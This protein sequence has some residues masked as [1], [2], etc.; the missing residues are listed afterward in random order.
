MPSAGGILG[1][2][3]PRWGLREDQQPLV[4]R[5]EEDLRTGR[6]LDASRQHLEDCP[7]KPLDVY[8]ISKGPR[9]DYRPAKG[10]I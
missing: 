2:V 8:R 3:E 1:T 7:E 10:V 5:T 6:S 4:S 9:A